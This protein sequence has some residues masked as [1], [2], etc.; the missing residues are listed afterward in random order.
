MKTY[1]LIASAFRARAT[2]QQVTAEQELTRVQYPIVEYDIRCDYDPEE[3]IFVPRCQGIYLIIATATLAS[4]TVED[5]R[6]LIGIRVNGND[7]ALQN[8]Y[9]GEALAGSHSSV[10]SVSAILQLQSN[11]VVEAVFTSTVSGLLWEGEFQAARFPSM[12]CSCNRP[13]AQ[14]KKRNITRKL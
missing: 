14:Y 12:S 1:S 13:L 8:A 2:G 3:S 11:D 9:W 5:Y 6:N 10:V 7:V 4:E